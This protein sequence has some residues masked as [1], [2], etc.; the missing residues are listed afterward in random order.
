MILE[1]LRRFQADVPELEIGDDGCCGETKKEDPGKKPSESGENQRQGENQ[2][3]SENQR[4]TQ[5]TYDT[6]PESNP[7]HISGR[8]VFSPPRDRGPSKRLGV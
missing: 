8:Q 6:G 5:P 7:G 4:Q 3:Q 1:S 2:Q